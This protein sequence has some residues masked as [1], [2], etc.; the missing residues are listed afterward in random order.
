MQL[1]MEK[2]WRSFANTRRGK[3][4]K[5]VVERAKHLDRRLSMGGALVQAACYHDIGYAA[6]ARTTGFHPLDGALLARRHGLDHQ[7]ADAVLFHTGAFGEMRRLRPDLA[8]YYTNGCGMTQ[9]L[10]SRALTFCDLRTGVDGQPVSLQERLKDIQNRH[11]KNT[12][13]LE[14]IKEYT[15]IFREIDQE[16]ANFSQ[17][18][19]CA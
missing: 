9:T 16:F 19:L 18:P 6:A 10:L 5:A 11:S 3:H 8:S 1:D 4:I 2:P 13:L 7:V 17:E 12:G 15:P 14:A